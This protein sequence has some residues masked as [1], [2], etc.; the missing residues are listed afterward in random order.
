MHQTKK[1]ALIK[2]GK[3]HDILTK[4]ATLYFS[5]LRATSF[6]FLSVFNS[7]KKKEKIKASACQMTENESHKKHHRIRI[8]QRKMIRLDACTSSAY[9]KLKKC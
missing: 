6:N 5:S 4:S 7:G 3:R 2:T 1:P 9:R 8:S